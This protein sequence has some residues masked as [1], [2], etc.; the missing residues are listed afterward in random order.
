[1]HRGT[2]GVNDQDYKVQSGERER[3]RERE[4]ERDYH[5]RLSWEHITYVIIID[6]N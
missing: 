3:D 2:S 4:G 5:V 1:M 6:K